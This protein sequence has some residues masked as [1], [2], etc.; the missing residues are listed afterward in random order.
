MIHQRI[1]VA[2]FVGECPIWNQ[3]SHTPHFEHGTNLLV[4]IATV[5]AQHTQAMLLGE[6]QHDL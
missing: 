5:C 1:P 3:R 2:L 6:R 4:I